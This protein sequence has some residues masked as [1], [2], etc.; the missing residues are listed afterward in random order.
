[1]TSAQD[2]ADIVRSYF[3]HLTASD[4]ALIVA[5]FADDGYVVSPVLG[6]MLAGA[7]YD[8]LDSA[9]ARNV[10]TVHRIMSSDDDRFHSA[11]FTYDWTL[12][13]GTQIEFEGVDVF[14]FDD[15]DQ[16]CSMKIF[17]DTRLGCRVETG[18]SADC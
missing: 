18:E 11:H 8:T 15:D 6:T 2:C 10:L 17:Y 7:F 9:S 1:M 4:T 14:E 12:N 13:D 5:L 16:I 3:T